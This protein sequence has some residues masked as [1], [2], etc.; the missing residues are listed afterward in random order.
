MEEL[1]R[2]AI[3]PPQAA[4]LITDYMNKHLP[5]D[6]WLTDDITDDITTV[7]LH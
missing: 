1:N 6:L 4:E 5:V 7:C 2:V 3:S